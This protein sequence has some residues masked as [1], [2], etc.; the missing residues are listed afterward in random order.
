MSDDEFVPE[1]EF[2]SEDELFLGITDAQTA[3]TM[4]MARTMRAIRPQNQSRPFLVEG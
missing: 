4:T 3:T 1:D 2:V